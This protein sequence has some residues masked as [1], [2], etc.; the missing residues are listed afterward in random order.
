MNINA[1]QPE[2][3]I[4]KKMLYRADTFKMRDVIDAAVVLRDKRGSLAPLVKRICSS[5]ID[6]ILDRMNNLGSIDLEEL[7]LLDKTI[8]KEASMKLFSSFLWN[9]KQGM[10]QTEERST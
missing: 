2:E 8:R 3:V 5:K 7:E 4:I 9:I 6:I 10:E 1:E